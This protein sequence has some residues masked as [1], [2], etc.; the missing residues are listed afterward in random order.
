[1]QRSWYVAAM[2][3]T[4]LW[5]RWQLGSSGV[6]VLVSLADFG[7]GPKEHA[8]APAEPA[9]ETSVTA[10]P[11]DEHARDEAE[12]L[13]AP[14]TASE[15]TPAEAAPPEP[16]SLEALCQAKCDRVQSRCSQGATDKCRAGCEQWARTPEPCLATTRSALECARDAGDLGCT[17]I[18]PESCGKLFMQVSSCHESPETFTPAPVETE[19]QGTGLPD[20]WEKV[21]DEQAGFTMVLPEGAQLDTSGERTWRATGPGGVPY[22]VRVLPALAKT[23]DAKGWIKV[24][25][26][27]LKPCELQARLHGLIEKPGFALMRYDSKCKGSGERHGSLVVLP[28]AFV[29]TAVEGPAGAEAQPFLFG[30]EPR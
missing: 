6:L 11:A 22:T 18:V 16:V 5:Q 28:K 20:G 19:G 14:A 30:I 26:E 10:K 17:P 21:T 9:N 29:V 1:M 15:A 3:G 23:P 2:R 8:A 12:E 24:S 25:T 27:A 7:C 13:D 4:R